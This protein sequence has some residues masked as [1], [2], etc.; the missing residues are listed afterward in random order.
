MRLARKEMTTQILQKLIDTLSL[1]PDKGALMPGTG[2]IR[3]LRWNTGKS[4]QG[5]RGG[6]RILYYYD[7]EEIILLITLYKKSD[8]ENLDAGEKLELRKLIEELLGE[9]K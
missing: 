9:N 6:L 1:L 8:K 3:K 4:N 5:K 2:G 7:N